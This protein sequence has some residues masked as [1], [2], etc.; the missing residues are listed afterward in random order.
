[1][2][3]YLYKD[4]LNWNTNVKIIAIIGDGELIIPAIANNICQQ[5]PIFTCN[6]HMV[7]KVDAASPYF[8]ADISKIELF[9]KYFKNDTC[10]NHY[11]EQEASIITSRGCIYNC[12]FCG[13]AKCLNKDIPIRLKSKDS[14]I[15]EIS[16]LKELHPS[17]N[18]IRILDDLFLR[19]SKSIDQ[20]YDIFRDFSTLSWRGMVHTLSLYHAL[21]KVNLLSE[22][23]CKELFLGIES[24]SEKIRQRINKLG[25]PQQIYEVSKVILQCGIDL[26]GYF[27]FGFPHENHSDF[28][29]TYQLALALKQLSR[30]TAG[31]FR[32]SVFQFRP[33]HGT[34]LF[35]EITAEYGTIGF[36]HQNNRINSFNRRN[37]FNF[38]TVN[39]SDESDNLLAE[40]I[41]KTQMLTEV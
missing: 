22:V 6:N 41:N 16:Y 2:V 30:K 31:N 12:A 1:M 21:D 29:D 35:D 15:A 32:A 23:N 10:I 9:R 5:Q 3:K 20:A 18:S 17:L 27:I 39:Y 7:Y 38:I 28:E 34:Q 8:P 40:Y 37:Q 13:G 19:N 11:G 36:M 4:I 24:G 26:K 25:T 14:I 33:Y